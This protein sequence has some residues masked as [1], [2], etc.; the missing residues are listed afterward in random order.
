MKY[1][2]GLIAGA[3]LLAVSYLLLWPSG[4]DSSVDTTPVSVRNAERFVPNDK[5]KAVER[6]ASG[7]GTPATFN[8]DAAGFLYAGYTD[9]RLVSYTLNGGRYHELVSD[10]VE[11]RGLTFAPDGGFVMTDSQ[12][13]LVT[14]GGT[15]QTEAVANAAADRAFGSVGDVDDTRFDK[16]LYFVDASDRVEDPVDTRLR[17]DS[18]GRLLRIDMT[19]REVD[20]LMHGLRSPV[21]VAVGPDDDYVLVTEA[22]R[23]RV[24]RYWLKGEK[25]GKSETFVDGLPCDPGAISYSGKGRFW[26][27][28]SCRA[29]WFEQALGSVEWRQIASR[30]PAW[31]RPDAASPRAMIVAFDLDGTIVTT[32][33]DDAAGAYAPVTAV[34]EFGPWLLMASDRQDAIA[35]LPL[36][37][38]IP[39]APAPSGVFAAPPAKP[40]RLSPPPLSEEQREALERQGKKVD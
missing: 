6:L 19:T 26:L 10:L 4:V 1:G 9:G 37:A 29:D 20:V 17:G 13:G 5:L 34:R 8:V 30:W 22:G 36:R 39:D 2:I 24:L 18:S 21:G 33:Q 35:R 15:L 25:A 14:I 11:P 28:L 32:L 12:L 27:A 3:G 23:Q 16:R 40:E 31:L 7:L 38:A